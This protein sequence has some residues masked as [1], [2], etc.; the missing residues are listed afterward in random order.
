M[1]ETPPAGG[2]NRVS[3]R[4]WLYHHDGKT[5]VRDDDGEIEVV[6]GESS[7]DTALTDVPS[8]SVVAI[9]GELTGPTEERLIPENV[10]VLSPATS[11][12]PFDPT[13]E[14]PDRAERLDYRHLDLRRPEIRAIFRV[15]EEVVQGFRDAFRRRGGRE[16]RL[17]TLVPA[18]T[19]EEGHFS[20]SYFDDEA[21]LIGHHATQYSQLCLAG[22]F[23]RVYSINQIFGYEQGGAIH[24]QALSE[25]TAV[26][27]DCAFLDDDEFIDL[28]TD[29]LRDVYRHVIDTC[30]ES[31]DHLGVDPQIPDGVE[32]ITYDRT[33]EIVNEELP[34][35]DQLDWGDDL[36][37]V[38]E[39]TLGEI[40][41]GYYFV[42]DWPAELRDFCAYRAEG[43]CRARAFDLM[44]PRMELM[45]GSL[46]EYRR[47]RIEKSLRESD[48]RVDDFGFYLDA[49]DHG[50]PPHTGG[51]FGLDRFL[52][53]LLD[54]PDIRETILFPRDLHRLHP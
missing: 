50:I 21:V 11:D 9:T 8:E 54:L 36:T 27:F 24:P 5:W 48:L 13:S 53:C 31:L 32:R 3:V 38:A 35:A 37:N 47:D 4:G 1:R 6:R 46:R 51:S 12:L 33:V 30:Q 20:V 22:G 23:E 18:T 29:V 19:D 25:A 49:L 16:L 52:M 41:G 14:V 17:P 26:R 42:T 45:S 10:D 7:C 39:D 44:H 34:K 43:G 28:F 2:P 40:M 15:R